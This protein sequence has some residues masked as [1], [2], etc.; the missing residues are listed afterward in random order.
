MPVSLSI[1]NHTD[2]ASV[3]YQA[4]S[5]I[6]ASGRLQLDE[7]PGEIQYPLVIDTTNQSKAVTDSHTLATISIRLSI[8]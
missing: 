4:I 7:P 2:R 5:R 1:K 6:S 8:H 3:C